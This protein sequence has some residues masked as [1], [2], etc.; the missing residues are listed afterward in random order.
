MTFHIHIK[1]NESLKYIFYKVHTKNNV[2]NTT[3]HYNLL[4]LA[5]YYNTFSNVLNPKSNS[6][7]KLNFNTI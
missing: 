5:T 7:A 3:C 2:P 6:N 4:Y 1:H